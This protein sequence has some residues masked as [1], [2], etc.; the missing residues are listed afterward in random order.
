MKKNIFKTLLSLGI[1]LSAHSSY[2]VTLFAQK[3][4]SL[5][6]KDTVL[7]KIMINTEGTEINSLDGTIAVNDPTSIQ[8]INLGGSIFSL[9]PNKPSLNLNKK[10]ITFIGGSTSGVSGTAL[11]LFTLAVKPDQVDR[12]TFELKNA[13][14][15]KNDGKGTALAMAPKVISLSVQDPRE[16]PVDSLQALILKDKKAPEPFEVQ[17][18]YDDSVFNGQYFVSFSTTDK[19][20]GVSYYEVTEGDFPPVR[21]GDTYVLRDQTLKNKIKVVA[22]D[23]A[24]NQQIALLNADSMFNWFAVL[25]AILILTIVKVLV[26]PFITKKTNA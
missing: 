24:G 6:E 11:R 20:S 23:N 7:I 4:D 12:L 17:L 1:L 14:A 10:E 19:D 26:L 2:A 15:Y 8:A 25:V 13:I 9:W 16:S 3:V 22:I 21:S 5:N 18:G